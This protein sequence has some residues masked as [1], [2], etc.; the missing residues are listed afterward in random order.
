MLLSPFDSLALLYLIL[1]CSSYFYWFT[2]TADVFFYDFGSC[3]TAGLFGIVGI[4]PLKGPS[5]TTLPLPCI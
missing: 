2:V 4:F 5:I 1:F 3:Y